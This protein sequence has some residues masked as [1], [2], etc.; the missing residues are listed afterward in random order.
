M[1]AKPVPGPKPYLVRKVCWAPTTAEVE[2]IFNKYRDVPTTVI[3][4]R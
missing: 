4:V 3:V 2:A 1:H